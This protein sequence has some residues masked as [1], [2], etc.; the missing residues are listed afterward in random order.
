MKRSLS[1][2]VGF[3][4]TCEGGTQRDPSWNDVVA[5]L[6]ESCRN[7]GSV[8]LDIEELAGFELLTLQVVADTGKYA[9]TVGVDDGDDY[10]VK[11]FCGDKNR[12][13][14]M[15]IQGDAVAG[16]AICSNFEIVVEIF[17]QFF[18]SGRVSPALMN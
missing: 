17:K 13:G 8:T 18:D 3:G 14:I 1:W 2:T 10:D 12:G 11:V 5:H 16:S 9:L 7:L 15:H 6:E 4:R